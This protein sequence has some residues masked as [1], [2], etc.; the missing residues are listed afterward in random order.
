MDNPRSDPVD[1]T[2]VIPVVEN[3]RGPSSEPKRNDS[4]LDNI[5]LHNYVF[6]QRPGTERAQKDTGSVADKL[7][8]KCRCEVKAGGSR[9]L[10]VCIDGTANQFS[11]QVGCSV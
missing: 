9:N 7:E 10:V 6:D 4:H 5:P 2:S 8:P 1:F 3:T 11:F